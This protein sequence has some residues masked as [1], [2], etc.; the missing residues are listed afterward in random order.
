[1]T[2]SS[3]S[4]QELADLLEV[5][6]S[7][8]YSALNADPQRIPGFKLGGCWVIP[9]DMVREFLRT[10]KWPKEKPELTEE[11]VLEIAREGGNQVLRGLRDLIDEAVDVAESPERRGRYRVIGK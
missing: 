2:R 6:P 7:R 11:R 5:D 10:A 9:G 1:M 8:V 4:P 3:F